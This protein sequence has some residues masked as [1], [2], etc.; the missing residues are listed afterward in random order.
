MSYIEAH[1]GVLQVHDCVFWSD[2]PPA[3]VLGRLLDLYCVVLG[4]RWCLE[5]VRVCLLPVM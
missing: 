2:V 5:C 4:Y 3:Q 1:D